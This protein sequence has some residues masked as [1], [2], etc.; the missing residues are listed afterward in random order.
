MSVFNG[1]DLHVT[2]GLI[3][4]LISSDGLRNVEDYI[5]IIAWHHMA[6]DDMIRSANDDVIWVHSGTYGQ[7][8]KFNRLNHNRQ[9]IE[10]KI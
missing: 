7:K 8:I 1:V 10:I 6:V 5:I 9:S 4:E 3:D 2:Q